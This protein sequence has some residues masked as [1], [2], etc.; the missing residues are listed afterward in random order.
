M[1]NVHLAVIYTLSPVLFFLTVYDT[2]EEPLNPMIR[3]SLVWAGQVYELSNIPFELCTGRNLTS[4]LGN[5]MHT[6]VFM[7]ACTCMY[8]CI[9]LFIFRISKKKEAVAEDM[10]TLIMF[11]MISFF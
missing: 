11:S 9:Y 2:Y 8:L 10:I 6:C 1:P 7:H 3:V 4:G 5:N